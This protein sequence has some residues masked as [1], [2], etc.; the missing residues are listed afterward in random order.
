MVR[1]R[2]AAGHSVTLLQYG[3]E[4]VGSR[5]PP[6]VPWMEATGS[7]STASGEWRNATTTPTGTPN[8]ACAMARP[9]MNARQSHSADPVRVEI[10]AKSSDREP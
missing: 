10:N 2:F 3:G 1:A 7:A 8:A 9:R 4:A 6:M 5:A